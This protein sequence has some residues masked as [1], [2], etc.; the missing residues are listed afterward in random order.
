M[1]R[2]I[3]VLCTILLRSYYPRETLPEFCTC[4]DGCGTL[5]TDKQFEKG[6]RRMTHL[7][8]IQKIEF[9]CISV[10]SEEVISKEEE[11]LDDASSFH[12]VVVP[13]LCLQDLL[14]LTQLI[15]TQRRPYRMNLQTS[16]RSGD[17][18]S[19][20]GSA[21]RRGRPENTD[22]ANDPRRTRQR[23]RTNDASPKSWWRFWVF[24]F[25]LALDAVTSLLLLTP[26]IP[27]YVPS[28][29]SIARSLSQC[30]AFIGHS[31]HFLTSH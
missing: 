30:M 20:P 3:V 15:A 29:T 24:L 1:L 19:I 17:T 27:R 6:T 8:L 28:D 31:C 7:E 23:E 12:I 22:S 11:R 2:T 16:P 5:C 18:T 25:V 13:L 14:S 21:G 26:L 9:A 10:R 4:S